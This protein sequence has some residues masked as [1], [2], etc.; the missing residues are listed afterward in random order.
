MSTNE[1]AAQKRSGGA[2]WL[3]VFF[4]I[5]ALWASSLS[6]WP[7]LLLNWVIVSTVFAFVR[8]K[9]RYVP[10]QAAV[11]VAAVTSLL[12]IIALGIGQYIH[13]RAIE[14]IL[15]ANDEISL[16]ITLALMIAVGVIIWL[17]SAVLVQ[18]AAEFGHSPLRILAGAWRRILTD[19]SAWSMGLI[20][21]MLHGLVFFRLAFT[22]LRILHLLCGILL[23]LV[24][25]RMLSVLNGKDR[26]SARREI[27]NRVR[28]FYI[29]A[30]WFISGS[31]ILFYLFLLAKG[32]MDLG[33][34]LDNRFS[35]IYGVAYG[36]IITA[37]ACLI[38][39]TGR[40]KIIVHLGLIVL[41]V[42]W[43]LFFF[44]GPDSFILTPVFE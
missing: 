9:Q 38:G 33:M 23:T 6:V 39:F 30:S 21:V 19:V 44:E 25:V 3:C 7:M 24:Q 27:T 16:V 41:L 13:Q 10:G 31:L 34:L 35:W 5:G 42:F 14:S 43:G 18:A 36:G 29:R 28:A 8:Y 2:I 32:G 40:I 37:V 17:L 4:L 26:R 1:A 12:A 15:Y 22:D 11:S 20:T